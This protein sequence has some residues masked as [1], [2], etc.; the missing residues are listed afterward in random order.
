[1]DILAFLQSK[2]ISRRAVLALLGAEL[3]QKTIKSQRIEKSFLKKRRY[4]C[5][6]GKQTF[7]VDAIE[8]QQTQ[9]VLFNKPI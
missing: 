8:E 7:T 6:H 3:I 1:M 9:I 2:G 5:H 4:C